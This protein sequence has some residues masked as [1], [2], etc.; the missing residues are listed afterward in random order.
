[1]FI[2]NVNF[3]ISCAYDEYVCVRAFM[4]IYTGLSVL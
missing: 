4:S 1:M 2:I 3:Q